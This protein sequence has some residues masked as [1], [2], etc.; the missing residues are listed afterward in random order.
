MKGIDTDAWAPDSNPKPPGPKP[1][2]WLIRSPRNFV[3]APCLGGFIF[4]GQ[5]RVYP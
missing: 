4:K 2:R 1:N 5:G 3:E